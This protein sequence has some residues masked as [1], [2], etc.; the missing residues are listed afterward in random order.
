MPIQAVVFDVGGVLE[1]TAP[2][3]WNERWET[4]LGLEPGGLEERLGDVWEAGVMG[5][6]TLDELERRTGEILALDAPHVAALMRDIWDEYLGS[7]NAPLAAY[8][9]S[10]RPRYRTAI[11][12]NSF[13]GAREQE[14]ER[15]QFGDLCDL[16]IYSHEV[17]IRKPEP[18]I[19]ELACEQLGAQPAEMLFLDDIEANVEAARQL[20]IHAILFQTTEQAIAEIEAALSRAE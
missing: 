1:I 19:F 8:F 7:L 14:H 12:S 2:T 5:T 10:L 11:L 4:R 16:I 6:I 17:G 20:G 18:R 9:A 13:V 15:Y 3:G